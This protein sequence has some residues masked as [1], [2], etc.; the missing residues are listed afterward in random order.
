MLTSYHADEFVRFI[1]N[2]GILRFGSFKVKSGRLSPYFFDMGKFNRGTSLNF[3]ANSYAKIL[4]NS[5]IKFDMLFGPA[6]KGIPLVAA[7]SITL[8]SHHNGFGCFFDIPFV[9]N[10]KE[11]KDH[12]EGGQL[13]GLPLKGKI[14]IIDDVIT[15]GTS[16]HESIEIIRSAGAEPVAVLAAID[17]MERT[18]YLKKLSKYSAVEELKKIYG[19]PI[20]SITSLADILSFLGKNINFSP[21]NYQKMVSYCNKYGVI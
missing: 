15:A 12:G 9:F 10:R 5:Q 19:I 16:V 21:E 17:R 1:I 11:I 3:L 18:N 6:Y 7:I 8:A 4:L 14:I 20:I 13:V 2:K